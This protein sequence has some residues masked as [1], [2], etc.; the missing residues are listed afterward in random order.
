VPNPT[1]ISTIADGRRTAACCGLLVL[2]V[3]TV[4]GRTLAFDFVNLDDNVYVYA[5]PVVSRGLTLEGVKWAFSAD[6]LFETRYADYWM[7]LT[8]LT[9]MADVSLYGMDAGGHHATNMLLHAAN[10]CLLF[11]L[12]LRL[13]GSLLP[14]LFIGACFAVHPMHV[15]S[16]AWVSERKDT[17]GAL[18]WLL[19]A[20]MYIVY[21][22][23]RQATPQDAGAPRAA[24]YAYLSA[25]VFFAGGMMSKPLIVTL[26]GVLI[27]LDLWPLNRLP[28]HVPRSRVEWRGIGTVLADKVPFV[29]LACAAVWTTLHA[30]AA[31]GAMTSL[32]GLGWAPRLANACAVFASHLGKFVWP[33]RLAVLYPWSQPVP[34][35]QVGAGAALVIGLSVPAVCL[36]RRLPGVAVG[37]FWFLGVV[38][39]TLG[40][41]QMGP[42]RTANRFVYLAFP[43][44]Y[45]VVTRTWQY[46]CGRFPSLRRAG[47]PIAAGVIAALAVVATIQTGHWRNSVALFSHTLE[48]TENNA[49]AHNNLA[50]ALHN[51]G[52]FA[53]AARHYRDALALRP[54]YPQALN[55]LGALYL[56]TGRPAAAAD[57]LKRAVAVQPRS[58][59]AHMNL[60]A[61]CLQTGDKEAA[62]RA[63]AIAAE[64]MPASPDARNLLR[65]IRQS[66]QKNDTGTSSEAPDM[67]SPKNSVRESPTP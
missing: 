32:A 5:N 46:V 58:F 63:A 6:L 8:I 14:S 7:P 38:F 43:G 16:V 52:Q 20:H 34:A 23:R 47:L 41:V 17:L 48:V 56:Q 61:A 42:Q 59:E 57:I 51:R 55:N 37:W 2:L 28:L 54:D 44:L 62:E 50:A 31:A 65:M 27:L 24:T 60:A 25:I 19:S 30:H 53:E 10:A 3:L 13:T 26:P 33:V 1:A 15:E 45:L 9:R 64:I 67:P 40:L 29:V 39:P 12:M 11:L 21:V 18:F 4:Y 66:G 36:F 35:W 22:R 49:L